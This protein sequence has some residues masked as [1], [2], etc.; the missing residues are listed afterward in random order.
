MLVC[1]HALGMMPTLTLPRLS[2][3]QEFFSQ[4]PDV[5]L[6]SVAELSSHLKHILMFH[7]NTQL[8]ILFYATE[9]CKQIGGRSSRPEVLLRKGVLKICSKFIGEHPRWSAISIK[10]QSNFMETA[11]RHGSSPVN[12]PHIF[13]T[14]FPRNTSGW[15]L[16]WMEPSSFLFL[17]HK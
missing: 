2:A 4:P 12:W 15:L 10:L 16:L 17:L 6:A 14:P 5:L 3:S 8:M 13:R 7:F 9:I 11:L 1:S